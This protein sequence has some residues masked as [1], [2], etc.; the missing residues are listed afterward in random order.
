[1]DER[2]YIIKDQKQGYGTFIQI[3]SPLQLPANKST[4]LFG[5][6]Q[7]TVEVLKYKDEYENYIKLVD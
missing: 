7:C 6:I 3:A 5:S 4:I 2:K 1:M